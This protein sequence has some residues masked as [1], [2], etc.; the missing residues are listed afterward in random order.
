VL[1]QQL[2]SLKGFGVSQQQQQQQLA[3][4][5]ELSPAEADLLKNA[6]AVWQ[7]GLM[8]QEVRLCWGEGEVLRGTGCLLLCPATCTV[9]LKMLAL[10]DNC[11]QSVIWRLYPP[12]SQHHQG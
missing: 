2:L 11:R 10:K 6:A 8:A 7:E 4:L 12:R 5:S 1:Q 9:R 3:V